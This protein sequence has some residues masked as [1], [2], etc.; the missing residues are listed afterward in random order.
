MD[1]KDFGDEKSSVKQR[2]ADA[3]SMGFERGKKEIDA[4]ESKAE[5]IRE[6]SEERRRKSDKRRADAADR[7][8]EKEWREKGHRNPGQCARTMKP[9]VSDRAKRYR[10]NQ[11]GCRPSGLK[12]CK[13]C[14]SRSDVMVDHV[15]GNESNGRKSNLRWLC[16]S[17]NNTLGAEMAKTGQGRR[18]VQYN[19]AHKG[20]RTLGEYMQAVLEHTRG[21]HDA[22]GKIIHDTPKSRRREFASEIWARRESHGTAR[23]FGSSAS[24]QEPDWVTNPRGSG[25][26]FVLQSTTRLIGS[27]KTET[28]AFKAA[29]KYARGKKEYVT[30]EDQ[31]TG[32]KWRFDPWGG[33][34]GINP[35]ASAAQYRLAQA[36]LSGTAR[37]P[38]R[39]T[40]A[41]A[42][43]IIERTPAHL[44]SEY[45]RSNPHMDLSS[46]EYRLGYNLGQTDR[47]T[48]TLRKTSDELYATF[49]ANFGGQQ[50]SRFEAFYEA[51]QAGF[52]GE[53]EN[54]SGY[55]G[56]SVADLERMRVYAEARAYDDN[57]DVRVQGRED[58][59]AIDHALKL[60]RKRESQRSN[61]QTDLDDDGSEQYQ[62][63]K[64]IA[65]L[66]HG[67][68]VKEHIVVTES[69][70]TPDWYAALGPLV[71]LR[72]KGF[73]GAPFGRATF[74]FPVKE[75]KTIQFFASPDGRQFYL[76]GGDQ[77]LDLDA[78]GM[79][80]ETEW[81]R[82]QMLIGEVT[83]FVYRD[84]KKFHRFKMT[85]Y[86]HR[87]GSALDDSGMRHIQKTKV[88]P[89][90]IYD[91]LSKK[92]SL[93]GGLGK[94]ETENL[95]E[96]M[97]P[98][99]VQ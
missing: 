66:F 41:V 83:Y 65:E 48:A 38:T 17:C 55:R 9:N 95:V 98:G 10:A 60:A 44:R 56:K 30:V 67:R 20:A 78:L 34:G 24:G 32:Q 21:A 35:A 92:I 45:S 33:K 5:R 97:S 25:A 51:Y 86:S 73:R 12:K 46:T 43:E 2:L 40:K 80:P 22:A 58:V 99:I 63:A 69:I 1:R 23:G 16:R 93:A 49:G 8:I 53:S 74:K 94:I 14:G 77:E 88:K 36:V 68:P 28:A 76:R 3:F 37:T 70:H 87:V 18:T 27:H 11:P 64:R 59:R 85:D 7:K 72:I 96:G 75:G 71:E 91:T 90:M 42:R 31:T 52:G 4:R 82:D 26:R 6:K 54:P 39:M 50:P 81:Y 61:P 79:G 19:P 15:D 89:V 29:K 84:G 57:W 47:Q 62:Q 13:L